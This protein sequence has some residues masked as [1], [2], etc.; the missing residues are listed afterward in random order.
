[1]PSI[2]CASSAA[3]TESACLPSLWSFCASSSLAVAAFTFGSSAFI[4]AAASLPSLIMVGHLKA[5]A[6]LPARATMATAA[7]RVT[8]FFIRSPPLEPGW[9][10][11]LTLPAGRGFRRRGGV[12]MI[13][14]PLGHFRRH[15]RHGGEVGD[16]RLPHATSRAE[17]LE[18]TR[19][20]GRADPGDRV[21][22]RLQRALAPQR[23]VVRDREPVGLVPDLLQGVE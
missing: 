1:M 13:V 8:S 21:E 5:N 6:G 2:A 12:E 10:T 19:P 22:H 23:L 3:F 7:H 20:D 4:F 15:F 17:R 16:A 9:R 11:G 14:N 18:E